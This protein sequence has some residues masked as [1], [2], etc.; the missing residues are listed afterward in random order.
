MSEPH[1]LDVLRCADQD[2]EVVASLLNTAYADGRLTF[3]E[4]ADR[5]ALAYDAKTFGDLNSLTTDLVAFERP[6]APPVAARFT[7]SLAPQPSPY[8]P[9]APPSGALAAGAFTGGNSFLSTYNPGRV[10]KVSSTVQ[11]NAW[12]SEMR[13]DL[14]GAAFE[15]RDITVH[16]GGGMCEVKIRVPEGVDV[17]VSGMNLVMAEAKVQGL[18]PRADGIRINLVGTVFMGEVKVVGPG[19]DRR[20]FERFIR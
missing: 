19:V 9:V 8:A 12:L 18:L 2:R 4:H 11:L 3:D 15:S 20:R 5:I 13:V 14:L 16:L 10:T 7:P 6:A 1:R 17:D